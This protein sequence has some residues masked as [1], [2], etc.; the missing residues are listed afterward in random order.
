M[1]KAVDERGTEIS[2]K[3]SSIANDEDGF[4]W[5]DAYASQRLDRMA[6]VTRP[7]SK[8]PGEQHKR[9]QLTSPRFGG[10]ETLAEI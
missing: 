6:Q 4:M 8:H 9:K 3:V 1:I 5:N 10:D 7:T 2:M